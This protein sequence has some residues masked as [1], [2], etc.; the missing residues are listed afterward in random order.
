MKKILMT[1]SMAVVLGLNVNAQSDGFFTTSFGEYR[2]EQ[3]TSPALPLAGTNVDHSAVPV[4]SGLLLLAGMGIAY[5]V[6][7]RKS[8]K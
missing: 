7:R 2:S 3:Q 5:T 1:I 4:G 6:A 8:D